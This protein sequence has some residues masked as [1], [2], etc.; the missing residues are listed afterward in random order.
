MSQAGIVDIESSNPQIPTQFDTNDGSAIPIGNILE[1]LGEDGIETEGSGNTITIRLTGE[2]AAIDSIGVNTSSGLG[3]NPVLPDSNGLINVTGGQVA[4]S[5]VGA[6]VIQTNSLSANTYTIQIQQSGSN[7]TQNTTLNGVSHFNSNHFTINNGFVSLVGGG[8]AIDSI[9]IDASSGTG[10]NPVLPDTNGLITVTGSQVATGTIGD[11]VI[12]SNSTT[13]N[14]YK[15]E[16][17]R[18]TISLA[19]DLAKNGVCHFSEVDF[20]VD[21]NGFVTSNGRS[22]V[23]KTI[24]ANQTLVAN[25][26]YFCISP[27]GAL[28]LDL[29]TT[30]SSTIGDIIEVTLDGATIWTITQAASQQIRFGNVQTTAGV[31]G[32]LAST[33]QG[34]TIKIVYQS[35]GKWNVISSVGV[36]TV[37]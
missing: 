14:A 6:N 9:G 18:S 11:N 20:N 32:S 31:G 5:T 26:G 30:A 7:S 1:I 12:R 8:E 13:P 16:I 2:S 25:E 35:T 22:V 10:T 4:A 17:Q 29:P 23:W 15:I 28:S 36:L 19:A 21:T 24:T 3:T 37:T 33:A 27:G 34:D